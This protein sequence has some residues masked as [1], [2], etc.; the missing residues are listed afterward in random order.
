MLENGGK[1]PAT[2]KRCSKKYCWNSDDL[3]HRHF[4]TDSTPV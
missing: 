3:H 2:K 1:N 4:Q